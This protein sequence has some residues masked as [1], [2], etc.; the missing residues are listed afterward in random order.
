MRVLKGKQ[1]RIS[2]GKLFLLM[3]YHPLEAYDILKMERERKGLIL[4]AVLLLLLASFEKYANN[5]AVGFQFRG[6]DLN[7]VSLLVELAYVIIPV[8]VWVVSN[9][10]MTSIMG[11]ESK[12]KEIF[13]TAC[14]CLAPYIVLTPVS[15]ALS[16]ILGAS[17]AGLYTFLQSFA[18]IWVVILLFMALLRQ[19][20]YGFAQA[21]GITFLCIAFMLVLA[22]VVVF[23][24]ALT[25]QLTSA[26]GDVFTEFQRKVL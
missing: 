14:Y 3:L 4:P 5:F 15:A 11:G 18:L 16:H 21:L 17:E 20:N 23:L 10:C 19:N 7:D 26:L 8:V 9:F 22:A 24:I 13:I 2:A 1:D 12:P 25:M 6:R